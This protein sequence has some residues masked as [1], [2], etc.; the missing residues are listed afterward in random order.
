[1]SE[2]SNITISVN[3]EGCQLC[4]NAAY[5]YVYRDLYISDNCLFPC[6]PIIILLTLAQRVPVLLSLFWFL[7]FSVFP[8]FFRRHNQ[9]I[10]KLILVL[11]VLRI[12]FCTKFLN[13]SEQP[14]NWQRHFGY[15]PN[16]KDKNSSNRPKLVI[17][18]PEHFTRGCILST[19]RHHQNPKSV[20]SLFPIWKIW[21]SPNFKFTQVVHHDK[22][23]K[24][25]WKSNKIC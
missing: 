1:M 24:Y 7:P 2:V 19:W 17:W 8:S 4:T 16:F 25:W 23:K 18:S 13:P 6:L 10:K 14:G 15:F 9:F 3:R 20:C 22:D 21:R 12:P 11:F 5:T